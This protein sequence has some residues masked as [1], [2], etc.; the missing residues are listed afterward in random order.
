MAY[1]KYFAYFLLVGPHLAFAYPACDLD[2]SIDVLD[3][4]IIGKMEIIPDKKQSLALTTKNLN[5]VETDKISY[6]Q[7]LDGIRIEGDKNDHI[8][9]EFT[10]NFKNNSS[11]NY[12]G[13]N[14]VFLV[15]EWY[16]L[17]STSCYYKLSAKL[18]KGYLAVSEAEQIEEVK[19]DDDTTFK[20][21]F[22]H[23]LDHLHLVASDKYVASKEKHKNIDIYTY[24]FV[25]DE[26]YA[27]TYADYSKRYIDLYD[28]LFGEF[29]YKRFSI[30]ENFFPTG[31]S[32]P[33]FTLLGSTVIRL[34]FIVE[35]S[36]G[37]EILHQWL[38]NYVYVDFEKGNWSEGLTTYLADH[39]YAEQKGNGPDYRKKLLV[40]YQSFVDQENDYPLKT[41]QGVSDEKSRAI[42]YGKSAMIFHLLKRAVGERSF[43][44]SIKHFISENR[45]DTAG[46]D[47]I[48]TSFEEMNNMD[49]G[50]FFDQWLNKKGLPELE[51]KST[52]LG[53]E[54]G[55]YLLEIELS[56]SG[57]VYQLG[58]PVSIY[59]D[60]HTKE[61]QILK[62]T[63]DVETFKIN[64]DTKPQ[65]VVI[66]EDY[67]VPRRLS[68]PEF[69]PVIS[70]IMGERRIIFVLERD[71]KKIY[72]TFIDLFDD[73]KIEFKT[74]E[75]I[76]FDDLKSS[77]L[78]VLG[79]SNPTI[80][81]IF[82]GTRLDEEGFTI[83]AKENPF[84]DQKVIA[85]VNAESKE[86][87]VAAVKKI[88]HYG[89]YSILA[90]KDGKN[91]TKEIALSENGITANLNEIEKEGSIQS[92][93][94]L[95]NIVDD[96]KDKKIIFIGEEHDKPAH[97]MNQ[98]KII[99]GLYKM[100]LNL[101][102]GMEMFERPFQQ[103]INDYLS[104]NI[105]ERQFLKKTEYFKR[106]G[107]D[108]R[109]YRP[110]IDFAK[111][112]KIP[113][114]A[115]NSES[116]IVKK[117]SENGLQSLSE[118]ERRRIPE[119][120]DFSDGKYRRLL[121]EIFK[122][123][124][125]S[126]DK[127]FNLFYQ[128]QILWDE[129]MAESIYEFLYGNP[130]HQIV[131]LAG[132]GHLVYGYGIPK[133]TFRRNGFEYSTILNDEEDGDGVADFLLFPEV[134]EA[135]ES[136]K[137][138]ILVDKDNE[139]VKINDFSDE[140]VAKISGLKKGDN[141]LSFDNN[142]IGSIEDLKI[143]LLDKEKG[144]TA[145]IKVLRDGKEETFEIKF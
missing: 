99:E 92:E 28:N 8:I 45:F 138:G 50:W 82:G 121:R 17:L 129:T 127:D 5:I 125:G 69:P 53:H 73:K 27:K 117:V 25:E 98:L 97:H 130:D 23:P 106:W 95:E 47:D 85:V 68:E 108:Y 86:E 57:N 103:F 122:F 107:L 52:K 89:I 43:Q 134:L 63:K 102:I 116:E 74:S 114:I 61:K 144:D 105:D 32:M 78:I 15:G 16:P 49:L 83:V 31:Y 41:F 94:D 30:V 137:L 143:N 119:E 2:V 124:P 18:P 12:V 115:L 133:R 77:S 87:V 120:M 135:P 112:N 142:P 75:E 96:I 81:R 22:P 1:L 44:N 145:V 26:G 71:E 110:I 60:D 91:V 139:K 37:H 113:V 11:Q 90:F 118:G 42:G 10:A 131:V 3:S 100:N 6:S 140:S 20:V 7:Y 51:I 84:N 76:E 66:D 56:Q 72:Q 21:S 14:G 104:G 46:W 54:N 65:R 35:T 67:D 40:N 141:I 128:V 126:E 88:P 38:G 79:K 34:P 109:L 93:P 136:P 132:N 29:P 64:L 19:G 58:L 24:F 59:L 4:K 33:T 123:H 62:L 111:K 101:A 39:Y 9:I 36:L 48:K 80:K 70:R 55:Q 13:E